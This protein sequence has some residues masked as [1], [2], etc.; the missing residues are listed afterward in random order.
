M[1]A[2]DRGGMVPC[3]VRV[4]FADEFRASSFFLPLLHHLAH[5]PRVYR[6]DSWAAAAALAGPMAGHAKGMREG[7]YATELASPV[8]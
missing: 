6:S 7:N 1:C 3:F 8:S 5:C 4:V 2:R